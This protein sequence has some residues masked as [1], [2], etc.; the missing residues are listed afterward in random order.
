MASRQGSD[1]K[2]WS[3]GRRHERRH[4]QGHEQ[5]HEPWLSTV[6][7]A[8]GIRALRKPKQQKPMT[9][10]YERKRRAKLSAQTLVWEVMRVLQEWDTKQILR[11]PPSQRC[12]FFGETR[13]ATGGSRVS[14]EW[15]W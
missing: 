2:E 15:M 11:Y 8:E 3:G 1:S 5:G 7:K 10:A 14:L 13:F 4:E 12:I 6:A 9:E